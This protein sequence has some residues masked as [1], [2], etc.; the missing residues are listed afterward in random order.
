M[1]PVL[2]ESY[3]SLRIYDSFNVDS[4]GIKSFSDNEDIGSSL[5]ITKEG[6][7]IYNLHI[8]TSKEIKTLQVSYMAAHIIG[9]HDLCYRL[10]KWLN[11]NRSLDI[12]VEIDN[13][14]DWLYLYPSE[15]KRL[16]KYKHEKFSTINLTFQMDEIKD[17]MGRYQ[18]LERLIKELMKGYGCFQAHEL[19]N[20]SDFRSFYNVDANDI[21]TY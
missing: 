19:P 1:I 12:S 13:I 15:E 6:F 7:I 14:S 5:E 3:G 9:F 2:D 18:I 10:Y 17:G 8:N 21:I 4:F 20:L 16:K 11:Y